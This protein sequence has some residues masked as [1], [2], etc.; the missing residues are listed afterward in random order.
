MPTHFVSRL[1]EWGDAPA[2]LFADREAISYRELAAEVA[3]AAASLPVGKQLIAI[4]MAHSLEAIVAYLAALAAG[5]AVLTMPSLEPKQASGVTDVFAPDL[6]QRPVLGR[7]KTVHA[8]EHGAT[9]HPDLGLVMMTSGS[10][11]IPKAV[12]LSTGNME[13]NAASIA[14]YLH[15]TGADQSCMVLPL[16]YC[17]GLSV[18]HSHLSVGA[19]LY[20]PRQSISQPGFLDRLEQSGCTN[21]SGV[22]YSYELL[23]SI[24]FRNRI[25]ASLRFMTVAGGRLSP[26]LIRKYNRA[27]G[28][29]GAEL[30][31]MYGQTEGAAR[32]AYVPPRRLEGN[33][34]RIGIAVPGGTLSIEDDKGSEIT[35]PG[36]VG[37]LVYRGPNVMMGYATSRADLAR[38]AELD[39]LKTGDLAQ[40]DEDGLFQICGRLKRISKIAGLRIS[41]YTMEE[42]LEKRGIH[43]AVVGNDSEIHA[44][45]T[46]TA[47]ER[48]VQ[49]ILA[50]ASSLTLRQIGVTMCASLP[51]TAA[52]KIDYAGLTNRFA[53]RSS[54]TDRKSE[55]VQEIFAQLFY[56]ARVRP[57]DTFLSLGGDSLRFVQLS[58]ALEDILGETP[59][60][61]ETLSVAELSAIGRPAKVRVTLD[62][63]FIIRALAILLVVLQH[64]T[65]WPIPGG[66]AAMLILVGFGFARYQQ[67]AILQF[68]LS[69]L[70]RSAATV[71]IPYYLIVFA[72]AVTW[73]DIPW[74]SVFM[75]GNMGFADPERHTMVPYLYWFIEAYCQLILVFTAFFAI[76]AIRGISTRAPFAAGLVLLAVAIFARLV[77]SMFWELPGNRLIFTLPW[78][79]Y[80]AAIGWLAALADTTNKRA[81]LLVIGSVIFVF[82]AF[83]ESIWIGTRVKYLLQIPVLAALLFLPRIPLWKWAKFLIVPISAAGFHIYLLHRFAPE[84]ILAPLSGAI[85]PVLF[86]I[87][88]VLGGVGLGLLCW[89]AQR[90]ML[91]ILAK[92]P[93]LPTIISGFREMANGRLL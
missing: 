6:I 85:D 87:A 26:E 24:D 35:A 38:G 32:L 44:Y 8:T 11:G 9:P 19:S 3:C 75:V 39:R 49:S 62:T 91:A 15:L 50:D 84:L 40:F 34:N 76:P 54:D 10:T 64:E 79:L 89:W 20:F 46:G 71:L 60:N 31:I 14:E 23:E 56:P 70:L 45:C 66:S 25:P 42:A 52:G 88:S 21:L 80:L 7:W 1:T 69:R 67:D 63:T 65:L 28:Q 59:A 37:E 48:E 78:F 16:H 92:R 77:I 61:W 55:T 72:Y 18:L 17:Y 81:M 74:T 13:A 83:Y 58:I 43:A 36:A 82:F 86:S 41:H 27:L 47:R 22:P 51:R 33:E 90:R 4:E 2:L 53:A 5:H 68:N 30:F 73:G 57:Q 93:V 12:R 29:R